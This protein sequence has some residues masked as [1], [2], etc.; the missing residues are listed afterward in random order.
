MSQAQLQPQERG[1]V[2][3]KRHR[4]SMAAALELGVSYW[5]LMNLLRGRKVTPPARDEAGDYLWTDEDLA[6]ARVALATDL[7]RKENRGRKGKPLAA[8]AGG[9]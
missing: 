3:A 4:G 2:M 5:A 9:E 1:I 8:V 6:A 7:R